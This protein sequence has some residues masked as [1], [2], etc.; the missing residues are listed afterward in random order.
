MICL[1]LL[2]VVLF[3]FSRPRL[4]GHSLGGVCANTLFQAYAS[5]EAHNAGP[6]GSALAYAGLIVMGSYVDEGG[7]ISIAIIIII[8]I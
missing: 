6:S 7:D 3:P 1:L 8:I 5:S 4:A 2:R